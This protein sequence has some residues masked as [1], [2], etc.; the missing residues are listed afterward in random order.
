MDIQLSLHFKDYHHHMHQHW[1]RVGQDHGEE[2][3]RQ[4]PYDSTLWTIGLP[5]A[6]IMRIRHNRLYI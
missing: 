5:Y 3:V 4:Q 6:G 1:Y 2:A